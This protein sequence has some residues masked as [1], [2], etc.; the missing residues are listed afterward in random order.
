MQF[1]TQY[2]G[3]HAKGLFQGY[4]LLQHVPQIADLVS[5]FGSKR[6]LDYGCG[7][8]RQYTHERAHLALGVQVPVLYDPAVAEW[9]VKPAG[10]FDGV[11]C[12]DVLEHVPEEHLE[13]RTVV[14]EI[15]AFATQWAFISV[16]CRPSKH[17]RFDD[18]TNVHVTIHPFEWWRE[19]LGPRFTKARL[20]LV[21]S[22]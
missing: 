3:L 13:L 6:L 7:M 14:E 5:E 18:G 17:I 22:P 16:C 21:E 4:S 20:V 12:T 11:I 19:Y 8:G 15:A 2:R 10:K 1:V 9:V